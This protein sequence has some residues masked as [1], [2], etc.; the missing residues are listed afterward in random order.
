MSF[1]FCIPILHFE[2]HRRI[3][4][5]LS[6]CLKVF[7]SFFSVSSE[8]LMIHNYNQHEINLSDQ[9]LLHTK[10]D[11]QITMVTIRTRAV[12]FYIV[13]TLEKSF[14]QIYF[15][16]CLLILFH[17][18]FT[19]A[20]SHCICK[21]NFMTGKSI[22]SKLQHRLFVSQHSKNVVTTKNL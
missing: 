22:S 12:T 16:S 2:L 14:S 19:F 18:S 21:T 4:Q 20:K 1:A 17:T 8:V 13:K 10:N 5:A 7:V 3:S 15:L 11:D 6:F 9:F